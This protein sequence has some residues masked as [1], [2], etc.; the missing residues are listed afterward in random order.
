MCRAA[1]PY[2]D[3]RYTSCAQR[4]IDDKNDK[5]R[6]RRHRHSTI[7]RG[8]DRNEHMQTQNKDHKII[9]KHNNNNQHFE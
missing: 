1:F 8:D 9:T 7:W 2:I 4:K 3:I 5:S 6:H